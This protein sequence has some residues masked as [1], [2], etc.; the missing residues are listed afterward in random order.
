MEQ[1]PDPIFSFRELAEIHS[2][3]MTALEDVDYGPSGGSDEA[4]ELIGLKAVI[5]A[6]GK[7]EKRLDCPVAAVEYLPKL[8]AMGWE[9]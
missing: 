5:S 2:W 1:H 3:L 6:A 7:I 4:E 8:R 9:V